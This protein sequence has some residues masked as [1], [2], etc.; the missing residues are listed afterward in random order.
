ME[1]ELGFFT[2]K[3]NNMIVWQQASNGIWAPQNVSSVWSRGIEANWKLMVQIKKVKLELNT[4]YNH[5]LSTESKRNTN[6]AAT[7]GKQVVYVP[8]DTYQ[9]AIKLF[10]KG[11]M[12]S[13]RHNY[14]GKRFTNSS[15]TE[16]LRP[17]QLGD[18]TL[19]KT[20]NFKNLSIES[21]V[22]VNNCWSEAYQVIAWRPMPLANYTI[23]I[24]LT[25]DKK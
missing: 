23:G 9:A 15:N 22:Q 18:F 13:Y 10:Y 3:V 5:T 25:F 8:F 14:V 6:N 4:K 1:T 7:Y 24:A 12:L 20:F 2:G 21:Y 17:Y 11:F 16:Y 19:S